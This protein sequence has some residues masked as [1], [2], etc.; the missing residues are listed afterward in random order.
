[1]T[2]HLQ[3]ELFYE[4]LDAV[5]AHL[6]AALGGNK[7]VGSQLFP[8]EPV[9][10]A[11]RRLADCLNPD[12]PQFLKGKQILW[13]LTEARKK[14]IHTGMAFICGEAGYAAPQPVEPEDE[15]AE[16][17]RQFIAAQQSMQSMLKRME[18]L[19]LPQM[20]AV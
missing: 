16:L 17:Q 5:M 18:K 1:M 20:R 10:Q 11:A 12:R 9:D 19:A 14:G 15:A 4:D 13:L 8:E 6:V 2:N 3:D 7:R